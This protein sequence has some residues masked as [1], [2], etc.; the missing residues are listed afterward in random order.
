MAIAI[1][2]INTAK[3]ELGVWSL[4]E[5]LPGN[6][7]VTLRVMGDFSGLTP[8]E[9]TRINFG[10]TEVARIV[11]EGGGAESGFGYTVEPRT[12]NVYAVTHKGLGA[13]APV[14]GLVIRRGP[15]YAPEFV[16]FQA[17]RI[18]GLVE[19]G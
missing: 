8:D 9:L 14:E 7:S 2:V 19:R 18:Q 11:F 15:I 1:E 4:P 13:Q 5:K 12:R 17:R 10:V 16:L 3:E 6:P